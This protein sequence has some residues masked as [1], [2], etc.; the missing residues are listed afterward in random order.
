MNEKIYAGKEAK[1]NYAESPPNGPPLLLLHGLT[2]RWHS[3]S[4]LIPELSKRRHV[5]ALDFRGHG[6]SS[7]D[8]AQYHYQDL[9]N[10]TVEFVTECIGQPTNIFGHSLGAAIGFAVAARLG[11]L[12]NGLVIADNFL[13]HDTF[14][15]ISS[16]P[17]LRSMF[18]G[19]QRIAGLGQPSAE[20]LRLLIETKLPLGNSEITLGELFAGKSAFLGAWAESIAQ[21]DPKAVEIF[22]TTIAPQDFDGDAR[23]RE[24]SCPILLLQ[25]SPALGGIL[26]D[27]DVE[28]VL[29]IR[30]QSAFHRLDLGHMMHM[31]NPEPIIPFVRAFLDSLSF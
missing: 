10:D 20:V 8:F 24:I 27:R 9:V 11:A 14:N 23:L 30:P 4:S 1:L 18:R 5:Y 16:Q 19:V 22:F 17:L 3:F 31:E 7:H 15:E 29:S 25:A 28:R 21:L 13:Y 12:A 26:P 2:F 6:K